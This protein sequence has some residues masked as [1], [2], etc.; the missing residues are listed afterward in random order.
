MELNPQTV[1]AHI[2]MIRRKVRTEHG[3]DCCPQGRPASQGTAVVA[4]GERMTGPV[5][6]PAWKALQRHQRK[7]AKVHMRDLFA[8][9]SQR[10]ENFS[11][12]LGSAMG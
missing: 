6:L 5:D 10:F 2:F 12:R 11:L 7:M 8:H 3:F 9:D 4:K 1:P